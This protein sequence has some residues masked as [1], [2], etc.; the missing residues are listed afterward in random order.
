MSPERKFH[1]TFSFVMGAMML[2]VMTFV[3]TAANV[4]FV[5][6]FPARWGHA[7]LVAYAVGVPVIYFLAP[8]A[9]KVTG[10]LLGIVA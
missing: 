1:L 6:D 8:F 5:P 3:I 2:S 4:G 10:K 9:R 7:F